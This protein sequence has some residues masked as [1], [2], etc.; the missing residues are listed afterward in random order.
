[1]SD[2]SP[3]LTKG[4]LITTGYIV[5]I[6]MIFIGLYIDNHTHLWYTDFDYG[7]FSD[8]ASHVWQGESPFERH[9]YRYTPLVA[10]LCL[11]N[12]VIHP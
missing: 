7:V 5:R 8:A 1:M 11:V 6:L 10:Y 12:K 4:F 3:L 2:E 9:T